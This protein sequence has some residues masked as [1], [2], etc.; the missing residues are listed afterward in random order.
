MPENM[1]CTRLNKTLTVCGR[2]MKLGWWLACAGKVEH[3]L[4]LL[5]VEVSQDMQTLLRTIVACTMHT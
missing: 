3:D 5:F 2:V 1:L 4:Q